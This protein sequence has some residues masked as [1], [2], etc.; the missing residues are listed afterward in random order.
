MR[1]RG[2]DNQ[3]GGKMFLNRYAR[4]HAQLNKESKQV[5]AEAQYGFFFRRGGAN[6]V[7]RGNK[8]REA[9]KAKGLRSGDFGSGQRADDDGEKRREP[10]TQADRGNITSSPE[11]EG[12]GAGDDWI[13]PWL[14]KSRIAR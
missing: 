14:W 2:E 1:Y 5:C 4:T 13:F 12:P 10:V 8:G 3:V 11:R 9:K 6:R 7:G